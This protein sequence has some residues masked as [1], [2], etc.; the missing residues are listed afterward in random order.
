MR[1]SRVSIPTSERDSVVARYLSGESTTALAVEYGVTQPTVVYL[2]RKRDIPRR[3]RSE[4]NRLRAPVDDAVLHRLVAEG[5]LSQ[6]EIALHMGVS[7]PTIE[8]AM[9][10]LRLRSKRGRGSPLAHNYFW[11]GGRRREPEGY[12]LVRC[13][14]HPH[15]SKQGYVR[16]HRLVMERK[17]GRFLLPEE[18]VH[19]KDG[20]PRN[21]AP[22]NLRVFRNNAEHLRHEWRF[23]LPKFRANRGGHQDASRP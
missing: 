22:S 23:H 17:L 19:H 13:P 14:E 1:K 15:A 6:R 8:R 18:V 21:N 16:E 7:L 2:L 5:R 3:S 9:R 12:V 4:T 10:R 11:N 20:K